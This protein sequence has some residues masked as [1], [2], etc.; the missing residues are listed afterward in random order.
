MARQ[1]QSIPI[2]YEIIRLRV[3]R[4]DVKP[5]LYSSILVQHFGRVP[6]SARVQ[7]ALVDALTLDSSTLLLHLCLDTITLCSNFTAERPRVEYPLGYGQESYWS[8]LGVSRHN[9]N[10]NRKGAMLYG[11]YVHNLEMSQLRQLLREPSLETLTFNCTGN[12][13]MF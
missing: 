11:T 13:K 3:E 12:W 4:E 9:R 5:E 7:D 8:D 1:F 10:Y 6:D 2:P